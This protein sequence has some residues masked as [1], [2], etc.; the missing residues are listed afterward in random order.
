ML[1]PQQAE[2]LSRNLNQVRT[3]IR[4]AAERSGRSEQDVELVAVTKSSSWDAILS[5][6]ELKHST[7]GENRPQQLIERANSLNLERPDLPVRWH[8]IGQLQRNKVRSIL[9]L[10]ALIHS[11]DS[12]RL[13]DRI[14]DVSAETGDTPQ[15]LL[16]VNISQEASKSGFSVNDVRE[17]ISQITQWPHLAIRG[18]MTMAPLTDDVPVIRAVFQNLRTLRDELATQTHPLPELSMGMSGDYEIAIEEGATL[19]RIGSAIFE[20]CET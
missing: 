15:L 4:Q 12:V 16:Q 7:L 20:G 19:V 8:L 13:L 14:E 2:Q 5:L 18:L 11:V 1:S 10:P 17:T 9:P 3:R 6:L